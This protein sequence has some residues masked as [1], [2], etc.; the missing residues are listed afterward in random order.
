MTV[1]GG[2]LTFRRPTLNSASRRAALAVLVAASASILVGVAAAGPGSIAQLP[3]APTL[4]VPTPTTNTSVLDLGMELNAS[5]NVS[6]ITGGS[7]N[8]SNWTYHW[9]GLPANCTSASVAS[10]T[11]TP[12]ATGTFSV[13]VQVNDTSDGATGLSSAVSITVN[14]DPVVTAFTV[15]ASK[16]AVNGTLTFTVTAS[17][18]TAPLT[19][20]YTGLPKGCSGNTS[21]ITC[22]PTLAQVYNA[23]VF[24]VDAIGVASATSLSANVTV[25][26]AST[27]S[28]SSAGPTVLQWVI[29][30]VILVVGLGI[31][32]LLFVR[33]RREERQTF[34]RRPPPPMSPPGGAPPSSG[35]TP[36]TTPP[37]G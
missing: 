35:G 8:A 4:T 1:M 36:P 30:A 12:T 37:P 29:I 2:I 5:V 14:S 24:V 11:C 17:G 13:A 20:V 34:G 23:S 28:S 21:T 33:A 25:T 31:S 19:Y 6:Q 9:E 26:A 22:T 15:S 7:G 16:V 32:A 10:Y 3:R 18:G 27:S